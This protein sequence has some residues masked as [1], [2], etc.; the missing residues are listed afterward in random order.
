MKLELEEELEASE[1]ARESLK[2][3]IEGYNQKIMVLEEDLFESK[4]IQL[5]LLDNLKQ[6]ENKY[7]D[8]A[9]LHKDIDDHIHRKYADRLNFQYLKI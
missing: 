4:T 3:D 1:E 2:R 7:E 6:A 5:E 9:E 8:I